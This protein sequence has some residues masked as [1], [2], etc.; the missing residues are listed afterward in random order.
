MQAVSDLAAPVA[1]RPYAC[2]PT[3]ATIQAPALGRFSDLIP[4]GQVQRFKAG[5]T[6]WRAEDTPDHVLIIC[7][8]WA[9]RFR[10][11]Q[12]GSRQIL[13]FLIP[14]DV[15]PLYAVA[16]PGR[17]LEFSVRAITDTT[18][19]LIPIEQFRAL[20]F[21]NPERRDALLHELCDQ[22]V[23]LEHRV[24]DLGLRSAPSR[25]ARLLLELEERLSVRGLAIE[26]R[27]SFPVR[28][29][30][31]SKALGLTLV[32]ANRTLVHLRRNGLISYGRGEMAL[33]DKPALH[34]LSSE[35]TTTFVR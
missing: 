32:H 13:R 9:F 6:I 26:S 19:C 21:S 31:F 3:N 29:E 25:V 17:P 4:L 20:V 16:Y 35:V 1:P 8:G 33:L 2:V 24:T 5:Q 22:V 15:T 10:R 11:L 23:D 30:D 14:G 12:E 27:F 28:Q 7:S 34:R 18:V